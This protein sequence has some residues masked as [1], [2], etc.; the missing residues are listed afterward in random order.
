M[1][2]IDTNRPDPGEVITDDPFAPDP[3]SADTPWD[4]TPSTSQQRDY[5]SQLVKRL[6]EEADWSQMDTTI[7]STA[8][9]NLNRVRKAANL[10]FRPMEGMD[11]ERRFPTPAAP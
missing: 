6:H 2:D 4:M 9:D 10:K 7:A 8:I 3:P 11:T 5:L 1:S